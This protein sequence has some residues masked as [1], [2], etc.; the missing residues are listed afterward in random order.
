MTVKSLSFITSFPPSKAASTAAAT[1][2]MDPMTV[3][4]ASSAA[5]TLLTVLLSGWDVWTH[6]LYNPQAGI[7]KYVIR[8]LMMVPLY[9]VTSY[10]ALTVPEWKLYFETIRDFYEGFALH[11]FY[12]FMIDYLGGQEVLAQRL[13]SKKHDIKHSLGFQWCIETWKMGPQ[14]VRNNS[15]GILQ[16]IPCKIIITV[17]TF[18]SSMFGFYGEGVYTDPTKAYPYLT[19]LLTVSQTWALYCLILFY[20]GCS[21]ELRPMRPLP[22]FLAVK[23]IIFFTFWQSIMIG[24]LSRFGI[25]SESWHI[26]CAERV[27]TDP[28]N[29]ATCVYHGCWDAAEITSAV[30]DFVICFEMLGFS[31]VHHY[32][33]NISDFLRME[34]EKN[35]DAVANNVKG[36]L[37]GN[38]IDV[39]AFTDIHQD[40]K[41]S[42][43]EL[44]TEKQRL[45]QKYDESEE[46]KKR[47]AEEKLRLLEHGAP[48]ASSSWFFGNRAAPA[49]GPASASS[50]S[51][52]VDTAKVPLAPLATATGAVRRPTTTTLDAARKAEAARKNLSLQFDLLRQN[53]D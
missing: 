44:L 18:V 8:M 15:I 36:P 28:L 5:M 43:Q 34:R 6:L 14:F 50:A 33:F 47:D 46:A 4:F 17:V 30:N 10:L 49:E 16:Y 22:K 11:S 7:R 45:A 48:P 19:L 31:I 13:R 52:V 12:Y 29:D 23:M 37:L 27:C 26:R 20:H 32:A 1:K 53:S 9:A 25:I 2:M 39:I 38:F 51:I 42:E 40:I 21:D 35:N 3:T 41:F 24:M